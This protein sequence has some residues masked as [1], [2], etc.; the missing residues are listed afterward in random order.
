MD[1]QIISRTDISFSIKFVP[2][3]HISLDV[4]VTFS[5]PTLINRFYLVLLFVSKQSSLVKKPTEN[6]QFQ[7]FK[8]KYEIGTGKQEN[9]LFPIVK[10]RLQ[11]SVLVPLNKEILTKNI[12]QPKE[13]MS[14]TFPP[15]TIFLNKKKICTRLK[16]PITQSTQK[17]PKFSK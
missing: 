3:L 16:E 17:S 1:I 14:Y 13:K 9:Q 7:N 5:D 4:V 11:C 10:A 12:F 6:W 2:K 8:G 15:K